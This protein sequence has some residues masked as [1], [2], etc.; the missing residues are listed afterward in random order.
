MDRVR[1]V[2]EYVNNKIKS[3]KVDEGK[4]YEKI[5][6]NE[7]THSY[8]T[9]SMGKLLAL[10]RGLDIE[11]ALIIGHMHDLGR[12]VHNIRGEGHGEACRYE[13]EKGLD[14]VGGFTDR[15]R[16]IIVKAVENHDKKFEIGEEYEELIKDAD[17]MERF[18]SKPNYFEHE[19]NIDKRDRIDVILKELGIE[20]FFNK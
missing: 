9:A 4:D 13:V 7:R 8:G 5:S 16:Y 20:S 1:C 17:L 10:K 18:L 15:E 14:I 2:K 3:T 12:I 11:L 19:W 6:N